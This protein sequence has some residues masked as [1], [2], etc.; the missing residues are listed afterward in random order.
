MDVLWYNNLGSSIHLEP[1]LTIAAAL[2]T[3]ALCWESDGDQSKGFESSLARI[4][5]FL[6]GFE[7]GCCWQP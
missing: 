3:T 2:I 1:H 4:Q 6:F 7:C 5:K